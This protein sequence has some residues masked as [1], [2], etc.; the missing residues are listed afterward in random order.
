MRELGLTAKAVNSV[1]KA[2]EDKN[3]ANI[4]KLV[5]SKISVILLSPEM[6]T[7]PG[8]GYLLES[9][10]FQ[11]RLCAIAVDEVHLLATW[12][13]RFRPSFRQIGFMRPRFSRHIVM[14]ALTATLQPKHLP[15]ICRQLGFHDGKYHL[16]R[17]SNARHNIQ[18]IFRTL[19]ATQATERFPQLDWVLK[20]PG[21]T[22]IFCPTIRF[23]FK[24]A[25]DLWHL[26][27]QS[28]V[29]NNTIR[30]FNSLNSP[31]YNNQT[32]KLLEGNQQSR[33]TIATDKLSVG[34]DIS[35]F[36]T[37]IIIDPQDLDDLWQKAGRGG[38]DSSKIPHAR[39][40]VYILA[41]KMKTLIAQSSHASESGDP[42]Q[43]KR[44]RREED[45]VID[46]GLREV[47]LA[48]C[49]CAELD[50]QYENPMSDP[51]CSPSCT[52]CSVSPPLP[53]PLLCNCSKCI[54]ED[55]PSQST[56][57]RKPRKI[58]WPLNVRVTQD[59]RRIGV[60]KL[61]EF[62]EHLWEAAD[63]SSTGMLPMESFLPRHIIES[64]LDN[65][66]LLLSRANIAPFINSD[67]QSIDYTAS[68]TLLQPFTSD[69][70]TTLTYDH[71]HELLATIWELHNDFDRIRLQ[72]KD[73]AKAKRD[74][75]RLDLADAVLE[76]TED[77]L[78][79]PADEEMEDMDGND[80]SQGAAVTNT[81]S[82]IKFKINLR[83]DLDYIT[84]IKFLMS[85]C[86]IGKSILK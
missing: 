79:E 16:V 54:P 38:R 77:N 26:D 31:T 39:V 76:C 40:I 36:Q 27:P 72:K 73:D 48:D 63:E 4:W 28:A 10:T 49:H 18:L 15:S 69:I 60:N 57:S 41:G 68:R 29:R 12:G 34:V 74:A 7:S 2:E 5:E 64:I 25:I 62:R 78:Q 52:T 21:K 35:D 85:V 43:K 51:L 80:A 9:K 75:K 8:F 17:R 46:S 42:K 20:E 84:D 82:G 13:D 56:A 14:F 6:L 1:T 11:S 47:V 55:V 83:Y 59:M 53:P 37:V 61:E 3:G 45:E 71:S 24:L 66:T 81:S 32:L 33:I 44:K 50:R 58:Q 30:L 65:F 19:K 86:I 23:G 22:L 67:G 70:P